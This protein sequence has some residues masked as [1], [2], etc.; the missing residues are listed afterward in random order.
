MVHRGTPLASRYAKFHFTWHTV[1]MTINLFAVAT[2][3]HACARYAKMCGYA[4]GNVAGWHV[5]GLIAS[6]GEGAQPGS[7]AW[8]PRPVPAACSASDSALAPAPGGIRRRP[9]QRRGVVRGS[10]GPTR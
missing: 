8:G 5:G 2:Y 3:D 9:G 7:G 10:W 1:V 6:R 4:G